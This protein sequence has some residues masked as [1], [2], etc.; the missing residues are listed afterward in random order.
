MRLQ[1]WFRVGFSYSLVL[2]S[3]AQSPI[4]VERPKPLG[5]LVDVG[6]YRV[7]LYCLGTGSPAVIITGAGYSFDWGL[8]QPKIAKHTEVCAYDHSD[9]AWSDPGPADSCPLRVKEL[10]AA[11]AGVGVSGPYVLVGH[12]LGALVSRLY[13]LTYPQ[14]WTRTH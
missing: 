8:V 5:R 14:E 6:G 7:H 12:S 11:L 1:R 3:F 4:N 13:A 2:G 9:V 10:H